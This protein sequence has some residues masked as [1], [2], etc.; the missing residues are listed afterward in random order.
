[1]CLLYD[2]SKVNVNQSYA[3][4]VPRYRILK[5]Q[6]TNSEEQIKEISLLLFVMLDYYQPMSR[7]LDII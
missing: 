3:I 7:S 2:F 5:L 6:D 1:M 4:I